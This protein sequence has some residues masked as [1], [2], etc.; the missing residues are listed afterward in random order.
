MK[1]FMMALA[2]VGLASTAMAQETT[3]VPTKRYH[4]VTNSFW[5]NWYLQAGFMGTASYTSQEKSDISGN[6]FSGTRGS[7]GFSFAVG[8][9]F[10]PGLGLRTKFQGC[11][12][13]NVLD[14]G[15]ANRPTSKYFTIH[16][17]VIFNLS[18]LF[19]GYNEKRVWNLSIYPGIGFTHRMAH[20]GNYDLTYH[21]GVINTW[22][23]AKHWNIFLDVNAMLTE[24]TQLAYG[25][26]VYHEWKNYDKW[27]LRHWDKLINAELGVTYNLGKCT[28]EKAPDVDALVKNYQGQIGDL[29]ASLKEQQDENARLR[30]LLSKQNTGNDGAA[31]VVTKKE[32]VSTAASVFFDINSSKIASRKD[33]IN[34]QEIADYAKANGSN[35][36]VTGYADSQTG[37]TEINQRLSEERAKAVADELVKMGV[38][39]SKITTKSEGGVDV[40]S[41]Y[42][43]NR[44][45]TVKVQ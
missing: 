8:K 41:P 11:W 28:W 29:E 2:L 20:D 16:E 33:L 22:R 45:A 40:L 6:P 34:V 13:K 30:N 35:V 25:E 1:K 14:E 38:D 26:G 18:N 32:V 24:G 5:A 23:V 7:F 42:S 4:V 44:R 15:H 36:V 17:D 27:S 31:K 39:S 12:A 37:N 3:E 19:F 9:W 21:L 10:T 43:Y